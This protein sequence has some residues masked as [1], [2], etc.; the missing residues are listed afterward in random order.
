MSDTP[1]IE[2]ICRSHGNDGSRLLDIAR[3]VQAHY[4]CVSSRSME[5]IAA[6]LNVRRVEVES[7]VTFYAFLSAEP[8]GKIVI[9]VCDD[10]VDRLFGAHQVL[11]AFADEL[12]VAVGCGGTTTPA[13]WCG[14]S[15]TGTTLT[16]SSSRW[17]ATTSTCPAT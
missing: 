5:E 9:R 15:G 11:E 2:A 13:C 16:R 17:C 3:D 6:C 12:G 10:V 1:T 14:R 7:L 8:K 4:G